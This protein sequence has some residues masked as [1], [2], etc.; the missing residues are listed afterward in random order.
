[1]HAGT[2]KICGAS[3]QA[4][5]LEDLLCACGRGTKMVAFHVGRGHNGTGRRWSALD[6]DLPAEA[7]YN[8][9]NVANQRS[10]PTTYARFVGAANR[11]GLHLHD[12]VSLSGLQP[13]AAGGYVTPDV[14]LSFSQVA[15][16][17]NMSVALSHTACYLHRTI[18]HINY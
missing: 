2:L 6:V 17:R 1:M 12:L 3:T 10:V 16:M 18:K 5:T 13:H 9:V 11:S 4:S 7:C 14:V 8:F 15:K